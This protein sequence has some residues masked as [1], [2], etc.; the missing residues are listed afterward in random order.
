[1][2]TQFNLSELATASPYGVLAQLR[3][4]DP[5]HWSP[6]LKAWLVTRYADVK[7]V[8]EDEQTYS[9]SRMR[10]FF[11]SLNS[12]QAD[13]VRT[14]RQYIPLW[15]V[16]R[17]PPDHTRLRKVMRAPLAQKAM[18]GLRDR[19]GLM[20]DELIDE[21][22][23][24]GV[25]ELMNAFSLRLPGYVI[26]DMLGAPRSDLD[27][28]THYTNELQLFLGQ[29][30]GA[31]DRYKRAE[32]AAVR[33][34]E[35]F[36]RLVASKRAHPGDDLTTMLIDGVSKGDLSADELI[37]YCMLIFFG[38]QETTANLIGNGLIALMRHRDELDKLRERPELARSAVAECLRYDG[39]IGA[40]VR[41]VARDHE[42]G[43]K[44]LRS[45]ERIFAMVNAANRDPAQ[46]TDPDLFDIERSGNRHL[47]FG[48][49]LHFCLGAPLAGLEAEIALAKLV[50]RLEGVEYA[51]KALDWRDGLNM[52]GV[53]SL[54]LQFTPQARQGR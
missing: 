22:V 44:A 41:I 4:E 19:I 39:P 51:R 32:S 14:L 3:E 46:F 45:G 47:T 35:Y 28:L 5:V 52:R 16:F 36:G 6:E 30:K 23:E 15:L 31:P 43:G 20:V 9:A 21:F 7:T 13:S 8:L 17:A 24:Q 34:E 37:S 18:A 50:A 26:L 12:V 10:P 29:A 54:P 2:T 53:I 49:G 25:V 40:V 33:M 42:F 48:Q 11:E 1:M 27:E 38:G